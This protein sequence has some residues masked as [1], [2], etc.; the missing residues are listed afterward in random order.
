MPLSRRGNRPATGDR[1]PAPL[2][3][4][5]ALGCA[6]RAYQS[7]RLI[8]GYTQRTSIELFLVLRTFGTSA[9]SEILTKIG[10]EKFFVMSPLRENA[11]ILHNQDSQ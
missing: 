5:A 7:T 2:K 8:I 9:A 10:I 6:F 4:A 1:R 11:E 3:R